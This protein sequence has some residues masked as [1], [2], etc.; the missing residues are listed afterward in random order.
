MKLCFIANA[1]SIHTIRWVNYFAQQG[2]QVSLITDKPASVW[3]RTTLSSTIT[4][5]DLTEYVNIRKIRYLLWLPTIKRLLKQIRPDVLHA[6]NISGAGWLGA[7][8]GYHPFII[9]SHGSDLML[10]SQK[11]W[12]HRTLSLYAL[13]KVDH[14]SCV[15]K[16]LQ[17]KAISFGVPANKLTLIDL[18]IDTAIYYPAK[19]VKQLRFKL[20][21]KNAPVILSIRAIQKIYNPLDI[22]NAIPF[23]LKKI[24]AAQFVIFTYNADAAM[25]VQL[26]DIIHGMGVTQSVHFV[27]KLSTEP[28]IADYYRAA[29]VVVSVPLSD[30]T[31][32]SVQESMACGAVPVLSD[33]PALHEWV[34]HEQEVLFVPTGEN[35]A[36]GKAI[37]RL[38]TDGLLRQELSTNGINLIRQQFDS[39][40]W[41]HRNEEMY[42][43][44]VEENK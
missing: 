42:K 38:L 21:L 39:R 9:T 19:D 44:I 24:P 20:G 40:I 11:S 16:A 36:L 18:G 14:L 33:L 2:H 25:L 1:D 23:I 17:E 4:L 43:E 22:I 12:A 28:E 5:Y 31:P 32:K 8:S 10:L 26:Q 15:S 37:T 6:H 30:G 3:A 13:H 7:F 41:M 34:Q 29:D 27:D 35:N